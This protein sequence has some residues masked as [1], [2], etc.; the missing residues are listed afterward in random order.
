[1]P[2]G[3]RF[4]S[5]TLSIVMAIGFSALGW[6]L[7]RSFVSTRPEA[8]YVYGFII[9]AIGASGLFIA[10]RNLIRPV[11]FAIEIS[12]KGITVYRGRSP[13]LILWSDIKGAHAAIEG[14]GRVSV[15]IIALELVDPRSFYARLNAGKPAWLGPD[16]GLRPKYYPLAATGL[17]MEPERVLLAVNES[18][19][20]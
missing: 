13:D 5:G 15:P 14:G 2:L 19:R 20:R 6:W 11:P 16:T 8:A 10:V 1:M 9:L 18:I 12:D 7:W 17:D 3:S 4:V